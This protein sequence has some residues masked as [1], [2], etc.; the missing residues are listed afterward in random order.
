MDDLKV[1]YDDMVQETHAKGT[2]M[3]AALQSMVRQVRHLD[4]R[5][6]AED[7]ILAKA[8]HSADHIGH[9]YKQY[10][11][12]AQARDLATLTLAAKDMFR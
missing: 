4:D 9:L 3:L 10:K 8:K 2:A 5:Y 12:L 1:Q 11:Q 7:G 6:M